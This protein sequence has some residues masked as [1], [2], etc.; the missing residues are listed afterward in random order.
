MSL[1]LLANKF[2][3]PP[4]RS[5]LVSRP[6]LVQ[7]LSEGLAQPLILISAP[8]GF[9]KTTLLS[10]WYHS[11]EG[12]D[13]LTAWLS[14]ES[15]DND[16]VR[17]IDYLG[18]TLE[19]LMPGVLPTI[20]GELQTSSP[21]AALTALLDHLD[22]LPAPLVLI[23][24]DY[25]TITAKAV[26]EA[27]SFL[28]Q[29]MSPQLHLVL[30]SRTDPPLPLAR[31]RAR[32]QLTEIRSEHLCFNHEETAAFLE[33]VMG[34]TLSSDDVAVLEARTEGWIAGLKLAAL[35]MQNSHYTDLT[36]FINGLSGNN[37][38]IADYL[39]EEV[40]DNQ[41]DNVR[42]FLLQT[43]ILNSLSG[44][45]CDAVTGRNDSRTML[46][47]LERENLFILSM[48]DE[49]TWFRYHHLF[50]DLL[51][52]RLERLYP[53]EVTELRRRAG[54]W[55]VQNDY[56]ECALEEAL[57]VQAFDLAAGWI[58]QILPTL[59]QSGQRETILRWVELLPSGTLTA[60]PALARLRASGRSD[61]L[62]QREL[63]VLRRIALGATNREIA[64][65]LIVSLGTV[66][67][68][69]NNVF[70]K[71]SV[72]NRTQAVACAR[73]LGLL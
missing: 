18:G 30:S 8:A 58:A 3:I 36:G 25:H 54:E 57:D 34:L 42:L 68:H 21:R 26:H 11:S 73:E 72:H 62:T 67:K 45:L 46:E 50:A 35:S 43:S 40:I 52:Q 64:E 61:M 19:P 23:L 59:V 55:Y 71:L 70:A 15:E 37:R 9:G 4:V 32:G 29:H 12:R 28:I 31:L 5:D 48:D 24:E 14:L 47:R 39:I 63:E 7:M 13:W 33:R 66:K 65:I 22:G 44:P 6:R 56:P 20:R 51:R 10:E 2:Y 38:L 16:P 41:P 17:F 1:S 60:Y 49:R 69:L 27:V 53:G